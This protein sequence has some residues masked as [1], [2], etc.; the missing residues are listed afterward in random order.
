MAAGNAPLSQTHRFDEQRCAG[1]I[2]RQAPL[3]V[4]LLRAPTPAGA[5]AAPAPLSHGRAAVFAALLAKARGRI[6]GAGVGRAECLQVAVIAACHLRR[7]LACE[8]GA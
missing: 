4:L 2:L 3:L 5:A 1:T 7:A 8:S 6:L